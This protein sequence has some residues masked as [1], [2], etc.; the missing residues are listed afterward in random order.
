MTAN[1]LI[2]TLSTDENKISSLNRQLDID[3]N[4]FC[5]FIRAVDK[6]RETLPNYSA[7]HPAAISMQEVTIRDLNGTNTP[8]KGTARQA[9]ADAVTRSR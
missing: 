5:N 3:V 6:H 2:E 9:E 8:E 1:T 4:S 7:A